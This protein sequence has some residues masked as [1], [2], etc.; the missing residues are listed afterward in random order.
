MGPGAAAFLGLGERAPKNSQFALCRRRR[1]PRR[2]RHVDRLL[3]RPRAASGPGRSSA[4]W[5]SGARRIAGPPSDSAVDM[6]LR[7]DDARTS[8]TFPPRQQQQPTPQVAG[9]KRRS[10]RAIQSRKTDH[11]SRPGDPPHLSTARLP[12]HSRKHPQFLTV[13]PPITHADTPNSSRS[14]PRFLTDR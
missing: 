9:S 8:P 14:F 1:G 4:R 10:R 11:W 7:L 2:N 12:S 13:S 5:L 3:Q 6:T